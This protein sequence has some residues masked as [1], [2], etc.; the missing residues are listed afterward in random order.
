MCVIWAVKII[1]TIKYQGFLFVAVV[2]LL[3]CSPKYAVNTPAD[4]GNDKPA[5]YSS[6]LLWAAHPDKHDPSDSIPL[7]L[8]K[9]YQKDSSVDVFFI[10]PTSFTG[11]K[12]TKW[13]ADFTDSA[14]N[15]K[16]DRSSILYQASVFNRYNVYAPRYRQAHIQNY[17]STDTVAAMHAFD[18]AYADI[19]AAFEYYLQHY[20]NGKPII[21]ASH[22]QGTTHA[23]RL[24]K[25]F[26]EGK[27]LKNKLVAA[28]II[29]M[30]VEPDYFESLGPCRDSLQTGCFVSWR[31]FRRGY[32]P[33][34]KPSSRRSIVVNP[35]RW[36]TDTIY[37]PVDLNKGSVLT[38]FNTVLPIVNDAQVYKDLLWISRPRFPGGKFYRAKNYH[39]GDINL[40][41]MNIRENLDTRV[42]QFKKQQ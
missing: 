41:Y 27:E 40:F 6:L 18:F 4:P 12:L 1:K 39:V 2:S 29:G 34:Y 31:T 26:F 3:A 32:E 38:K 30:A 22:S 11:K 24:L 10:H 33:N 16:T 36:A 7:P 28:Y 20:N 8:R 42:E 25:E 19:K 37:A 14:L 23:K 13:N 17:Y 35:L 9:G 5:D 21:I 15:N